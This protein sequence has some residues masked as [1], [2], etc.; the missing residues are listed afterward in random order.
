MDKFDVNSFNEKKEKGR[1]DNLSI[2]TAWREMEKATTDCSIKEEGI[3]E[4]ELYNCTI[5]IH[6]HILIYMYSNRWSLSAMGQHI[7][8]TNSP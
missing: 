5:I 2:P 8:A 7:Q 1:L 6:W 4:Y 3:D